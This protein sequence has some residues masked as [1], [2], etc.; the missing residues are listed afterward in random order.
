LAAPL[1]ARIQKTLVA[2]LE[3]S[4]LKKEDLYA[5]EIVGGATRMPSFKDAVKSV[6][7]LDPSTTLNTDEAAARGGALKCAILSPTFRVREFN[8]VDSVMNEITIN[9]SPDATGANSGSLKIFERKGQFPFTKA[10]TIYRKTNDDFQLCADL[11]GG[12]KPVALSTYTVGGINPVNELEEKGKKVKLYFRMDGSGLFS[13]SACEQIE[14]FEEWV[15]VPV[16]KKAEP[17]AAAA[18]KK[19]D[20]KAGDKGEPMETDSKESQEAAPEDKMETS[21]EEKKDE[22]DA[23]VAEPEMRKEK[24]MKQRKS[25]LKISCVTQLGQ[26]PTEILNRFLEVECQLKMKDKEEKD[27]SDAKNELEELVYALR[28]KLYTTYENFVQEVEKTNLSKTC[29]EI[30]DWLYGD[31]E[32]QPKNVYVE[33]KSNLD[34]VIA[35]IRHR[36]TEFENRKSSFDKLTHTLNTYQ[37]I[38]GEY[39]SGLP[40]S[41]YLHLEVEDVKKMSEAVAEGWKLCTEAKSK[42]K[43]IKQNEDPPVTNF[44][45]TSK[46]SYIENVC[47]PISQKK[48]P[49]VE[50]PK[51]EKPSEATNEGEGAAA[52]P[53]A[54]DQK[55]EEE[56][57]DNTASTDDLD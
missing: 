2:G 5:V 38:V 11:T 22:G 6:F 43:H 21:Q 27:K 16:E 41:K 8:I 4:G 53:P 35:P 55:M 9:W 12:A 26:T 40:E 15:E 32:D 24:K 10:M 19:E 31:G 18:E 30:E 54:T 37:K 50:P 20:K 48:P 57:P 33:R 28:D 46:A 45:I 7:G 13:L 34:A 25:P 44:D 1:F 23:P 3:A 39:E 42:L 56:K 52:A 36:Y 14:K 51:E 17:E 47:K 29:D 49:K